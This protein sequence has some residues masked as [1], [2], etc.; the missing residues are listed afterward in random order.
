MPA[1][2]VITPVQITAYQHVMLAVSRRFF[3]AFFFG[4]LSRDSWGIELPIALNFLKG[5]HLRHSLWHSG[6]VLQWILILLAVVG[7]ELC[8]K[9]AFAFP[10]AARAFFAVVKDLVELIG[11]PAGKAFNRVVGRSTT[12]HRW[13]RI[14]ASNN[15][16]QNAV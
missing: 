14:H 2:T 13:K 15:K 7:I 6:G 12:L 8:V 10:K 4:F 5:L 11:L 1:N 3:R 9:Y 16:R